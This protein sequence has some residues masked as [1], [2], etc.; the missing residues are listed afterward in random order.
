MA[1]Q[2]F[3]VE[4]VSASFRGE[5]ILTGLLGENQSIMEQVFG[6][7][8]TRLQSGEM[9]FMPSKYTL[10]NSSSEKDQVALDAKPEDV[11]SGLD[12]ASFNINKKFAKRGRVH[13]VA[14]ESME[15][16]TVADDIVELT[17][18]AAVIK[19]ENAVDRVGKEFLSNTTVNSVTVNDSVSATDV[20]SD[21]TNAR[22][23]TDVDA[24][25]DK[26]GGGGLIFWLGKDRAR[27]FAALPAI[28]SEWANYAG[29]DGRI[30]LSRLPEAILNHWDEI[31][32]VIIADAWYNSEN[33]QNT[34]SFART[35]DN[36]VWLGDPN[37]KMLVEMQNLRKFRS[38]F[39]EDTD[40]Y[41]S[42]VVRY[43]TFA[44]GESTRSAILTG[45]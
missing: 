6:V 3:D 36:V 35:F 16:S 13:A 4:S 42:E 44:S 32:Q 20:W 30:P 24:L 23:F 10:G 1:A 19:V 38:W 29:V 12:G 31:D 7:E 14:V 17:G 40:T 9:P 34:P 8:N 22:P 18:R 37:H 45:T 25:I 21:D 5:R 11:D 26:V 39:D 41:Y 28:K 2:G 43:L 15:E 27:E 33:L